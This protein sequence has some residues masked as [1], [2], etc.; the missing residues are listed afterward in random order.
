MQYLLSAVLLGALGSCS[1]VRISVSGLCP[2]VAA[3]R[4]PAVVATATVAVVPATHASSDEDKPK[5]IFVLGG[6]GFCGWPVALHL[7]NIGHE[8]RNCCT[9]R[10]CQLLLQC[11]DAAPC[12]LC[13]AGSC[14]AA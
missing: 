6:D 12:Y 2:V 10:F 8:V 3:A 9:H 4:A 11:G 7:S 14:A 5:K 13:W 1:A